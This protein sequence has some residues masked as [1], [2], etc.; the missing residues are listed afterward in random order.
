MV[1]WPWSRASEGAEEHE[2]V[3]VGEMDSGN[4]AAQ[5]HVE[6]DVLAAGRTACYKARDA[7]FKC[8]EADSGHTTPTEIASVGL[9]YP[10]QCKPARAFYEQNCRSTWVKHFDR[11]YCRQ[12]RT[13]RLLDIGER[14]RGPINLPANRVGLQP[15]EH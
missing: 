12:K 14:A 15:D 10:A 11:Q 1:G 7:F 2:P 13:N 3:A 5:P 8:V 9:L 4:S 6:K